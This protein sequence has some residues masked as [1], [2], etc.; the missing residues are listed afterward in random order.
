MMNKMISGVD[1]MPGGL[2]EARMPVKAVIP[3]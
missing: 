1:V 3:T 2:E